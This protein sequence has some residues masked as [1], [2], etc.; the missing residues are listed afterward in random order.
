[1]NYY[2]NNRLSKLSIDLHSAVVFDYHEVVTTILKSGY[3]VNSINE[4]GLSP[5]HYAVVFDRKHMLKLLCKYPVD[6]DITSHKDTYT[7]LHY[8]VI[9]NNIWCVKFL[10]IRGAD[11]NKKDS[12]MR[13]PIY[14]ATLSGNRRIVDCLLNF[15]KYSVTD[16]FLRLQ[17]AIRIDDQENIKKLLEQRIYGKDS[18]K[19]DTILLHHAVKYGNTYA[20]KLLL[21]DIIDVNTVD[22]YLS[23]P[24]HYAIKLHNLDMVTILMKH[25]ADAS[26]KDGKGITPFY[27]AMYL[28]YYGI[29]RD[30]LDT[31]IRYNSIN[32]II[33][34]TKRITDRLV[35][36]EYGNVS[37]TLHDAAR[38]GYYGAVE[39]IIDNGVDINY[40][41]FNCYTA[42]HCAVKSSNIKI[43][44]LLLRHG[45]D[46]NKKDSNDRTALHYAVIVGNKEITSSILDYGADICSLDVSDK[47]PLTYA[48]QLV[49]DS[50]YYDKLFYSRE[51]IADRLLINLIASEVRRNETITKNDLYKELNHKLSARIFVSKCLDEIHKMKDVYV[52]GYSVYDI[53]INNKNIDIDILSKHIKNVTDLNLNICFPIHKYVLDKKINNIL[54]RKKLLC[55]AIT[56]MNMKNNTNFWGKLPIEIKYIIL[57]YLSNRDLHILLSS[58]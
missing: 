42:L 12:S 2:R 17:T 43:V 23:T 52:K 26:I 1:M 27:Y 56:L 32:G 48:L 55:K 21:D 40:I 4:D 7:P 6:I 34:N 11:V 44:N 53:Y 30:I 50:Y 8:A 25:G 47:S 14:Y 39:Q 45:I 49:K 57:K 38:L 5:L 46:V 35:V 29:N 13:M 54:E 51:V 16:D 33:G 9:C 18:D 58:N 3:D 41:D 31:I 20:I 15:S 10:L 28:S 24:L 19:E 36:N 22:S 37:I